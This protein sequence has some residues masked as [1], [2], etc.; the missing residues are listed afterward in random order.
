MEEKKQRRRSMNAS[1]V[2][3]LDLLSDKPKS[4]YVLMLETGFTERA[5]RDMIRTL[6]ENGYCVCSNSQTGGYWLGS[7][8]DVDHTTREMMHRGIALI[9]QARVMRKAFDLSDD[10]QIEIDIRLLTVGGTDA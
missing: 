8:K 1:A 5:I 6:R 9:K 2:R 7:E 10:R 3:V 4:K